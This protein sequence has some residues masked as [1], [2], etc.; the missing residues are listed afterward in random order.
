MCKP[1]HSLLVADNSDLNIKSEDLRKYFQKHKIVPHQHDKYKAYFSSTPPEIALTYEW[2]TTFSELRAFLSPANIRRHNSTA[3]DPNPS[4][5]HRLYLMSFL[6]IFLGPLTLIP[7]DIDERTI[8]IDIMINDQ[9]SIDIKRELAAAE[10]Q[11][12]EAQWHVITATSSVLERAWCLYEIAVR[13]GAGGRSQLVLAGGAEGPGMGQLEVEAV[14]LWELL[15]MICLR[16]SVAFAFPFNFSSALLKL[17]WGINFVPPGSALLSLKAIGK[18]NDAEFFSRMKASVEADKDMIRDKARTV[19]GDDEEF[20][21]TI[22]VATVR[23]GGGRLELG[24]LLWLEAGLALAMLPAHA[25]SAALSLV[26]AGLWAL[27]HLCLRLCG[28]RLYVADNFPDGMS[29]LGSNVVCLWFIFD[30]V[31]KAPML[32]AV[33]AAVVPPWAAAAT[34]LLSLGLCWGGLRRLWAAEAD[35]GERESDAGRGRGRG[36]EMAGVLGLA[37]AAPILVPLAAVLILGSFTI[38]LIRPLL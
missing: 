7:E 34:L 2:K 25:A 3:L 13:R 22:M 29:K 23:F 15:K 24:L 28:W 16:I 18:P 5:W 38:G 12:E 36:W 8:F 37:L 21:S 27:G 20:D 9:N 32:A 17:M 30:L 31:I 35:G 1:N 6:W 33:C 4:L 19:F 11:Y 10:L 26:A 14:G